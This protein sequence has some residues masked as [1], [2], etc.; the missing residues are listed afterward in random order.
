VVGAALPWL[1]LC[2]LLLAAGL[3][4]MTQPMEMRGT[5]VLSSVR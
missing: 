5:F 1:A 2:L 3:W 4:I